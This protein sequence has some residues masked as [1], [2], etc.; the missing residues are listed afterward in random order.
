MKKIYISLPIKIDELT[1]SKRYKEA[2]DYISSH[3]IIKNYEVVGPINIHEFNEHGIKSKRN[4]DYAW[5]MGEDIKELLRADA[6][7]M[8]KGWEKSEGCRCELATAKIY[9]KE[10]FYQNWL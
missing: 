2:L 4:H 7:F 3:N 9:N 6:I 5:Y 1:V 10:V 8:S